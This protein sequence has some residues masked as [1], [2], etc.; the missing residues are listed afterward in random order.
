MDGSISISVLE[1]NSDFNFWMS[2][3][4]PESLYIPSDCIPRDSISSMH[5]LMMKGMSIFFDSVWD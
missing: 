3:V 4:C 2:A 1:L 5:F